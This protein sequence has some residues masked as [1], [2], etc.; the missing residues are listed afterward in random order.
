MAVNDCHGWMLV[1]GL[2]VVSAILSFTRRLS[3]PAAGSAAGWSQ[4]RI[5]IAGEDGTGESRPVSRDLVH[6]FE[7]IR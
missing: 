4:T 3:G 1:P 6:T 2:S 7:M 5:N